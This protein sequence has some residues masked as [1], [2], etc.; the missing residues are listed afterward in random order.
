M[1]ETN[2][3]NI[4]TATHEGVTCT[5][6]SKDRVYTHALFVR[7]PNSTIEGERNWGVATWCGRLDLAH[8]AHASWRYWDERVIVPVELTVKNVKKRSKV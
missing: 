1:T 5:R 8:K 6:T 7:N 3:K 4:H 2:I